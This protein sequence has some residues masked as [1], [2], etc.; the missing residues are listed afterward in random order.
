SIDWAAREMRAPE[1]GGFF[2]S[3]DADSE[4]HEGKFYVWSAEE[5]DG[6]LG[7]DA[8]VMRAYWGVT[9][10]GNFE[11]KNIL[12]VVSDVRTIAARFKM[13]E[14]ALTDTIARSK[15]RLYDVR[16]KRVWPG[17]D[18]KVLASWNGLMVRGIAE[19]A[20]AFGSD[21]YEALALDVATFLFD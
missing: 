6:L 15:A 19:A 16:S 12:S 10:G 11:G 17:R 18:D 8:P 2:S 4:G 14:A 1:G 20:R 5:F 21:A 3:L 9:E 7:D 13:S